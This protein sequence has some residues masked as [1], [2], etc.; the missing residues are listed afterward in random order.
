[1]LRT[2]LGIFVGQCGL[3]IPSWRPVW[4]VAGA[5]IDMGPGMTSDDARFPDM[6]ESK[7]AEFTC[8]LKALYEQHKSQFCD[9]QGSWADRPLLVH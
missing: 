5:P 9:G 2:S 7:H 6:V 4:T 8:A 3:P 1:M